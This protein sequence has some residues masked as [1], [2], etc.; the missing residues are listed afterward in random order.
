MKNKNKAPLPDATQNTHIVYTERNVERKF[1]ISVKT[2]FYTTTRHIFP[3]IHS[4]HYFVYS[5]QIENFLSIWKSTHAHTVHTQRI[6]TTVQNKQQQQQ[7]IK[8][9][10][11][12]DLFPQFENNFF[13]I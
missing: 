13:I 7:D 12:S 4:S 5:N 1:L 9:R 6:H 8:T 3:L 11:L 2:L 10:L